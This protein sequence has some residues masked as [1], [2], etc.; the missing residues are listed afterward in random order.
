M[1]KKEN[2]AKK[3]ENLTEKNEEKSLFK[4]NLTL[5]FKQYDI[6]F[7]FPVS[8]ICLATIYILVCTLTELGLQY[9]QQQ[10]ENFFVALGLYLIYCVIFIAFGTVFMQKWYNIAFRGEKLRDLSLKV[11]VFKNVFRLN[12]FFCMLGLLPLISLV[13]LYNREVTPNWLFELLYFL[14]LF[15]VR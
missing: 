4:R 10:T 1:K 2:N 11:A 8:F 6:L 12:L 5:V 9:L 15:S 3:N 7:K 14:C 13:V